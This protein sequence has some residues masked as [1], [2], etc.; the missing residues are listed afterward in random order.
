[1]YEGCV[2]P[3]LR[4]HPLGRSNAE[5][6]TIGI[7]GTRNQCVWGSTERGRR[8]KAPTMEVISSRIAQRDFAKRFGRGKLSFTGDVLQVI[9]VDGRQ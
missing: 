4:T 2:A 9:S 6:G 7:V 1:V 5:R 8:E 3:H